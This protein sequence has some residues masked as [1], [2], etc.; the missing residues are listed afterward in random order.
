MIAGDSSD[1]TRAQPAVWIVVLNWN[2]PQDTLACVSSLRE[3]D[4]PSFRI[5]VVDNGSTDDSVELFQELPGVELLVNEENLGFAAGNNQGIQ[6]ALD[7]GA[8]YVLLLNNDTTVSPPLLSRMV[9]AAQTDPQIG[10]VGPMI[11]YSDRPDQVWFAGMRFRHGL[12][13]VRRGLHLDP[14]LDPIEEVDFISGCGMLVPRQTWERIGLFDP[15]FFMYYEDLDLCVRAKDAGYRI[16]CATEAHMWHALSAST[17]GPDS[18]L[19]QYYQVK[20]TLLFSQKHTRGLQRVAT[21]AIRLGH[22]GFIA[23]RQVIRGQL[24]WEAIR[25]YLRGIAEVFR[26]RQG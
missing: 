5:L 13:V 25:F 22:A 18:P 11:Y 7:H 6:Y 9:E 10:L 14:P 8:D 2:R 23:L 3:L 16:I 15:R 4:Y 24:R 17:G 20:S 1:A 12:Y 26:G 21:L 19:K